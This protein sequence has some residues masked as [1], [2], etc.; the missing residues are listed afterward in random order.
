M[1]TRLALAIV[2]LSSCIA[3]AQAAIPVTEEPYHHPV[4]SNDYIRVLDVTIPAG[5]TSM[6][7]QHDYDYVFVMLK[8]GSMTSTRSDGY[9][10]SL[11]L[12]KGDSRLTR[13]N[14][15]HTAS[16]DGDTPL[17]IIA[18]ELLKGAG[19]GVC[20]GDNPP[21]EKLAADVPSHQVL[22]DA[23]RVRVSTVH[24]EPGVGDMHRHDYPH[25]LV[26]LDTLRLRN[27]RAGAAPEILRLKAGD[28][29]WVPGGF[30][31]TLTNLGKTAVDYVVVEIKDQQPPA[32][33]AAQPQEPEPDTQSDPT[34]TDED[35][36]QP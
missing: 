21:C 25:L 6:L 31:H 16:N 2:L 27:E 5:R 26:A 33:K 4:F 10:V 29:K 14:F 20:G 13:G 9:S 23:E 19:T 35:P 15:A 28:Y 7:H 30:T 22:V 12:K 36:E 18:V 8:D 11:E 32:L 1:R 3:R 17:R 34:E 24:M